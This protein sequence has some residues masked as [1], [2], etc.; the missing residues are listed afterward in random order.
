MY[1]QVVNVPCP[2]A[3]IHTFVLKWVMNRVSNGMPLKYYFSTVNKS[4]S[5][6][7]KFLLQIVIN[8]VITVVYKISSQKYL[9]SSSISIMKRRQNQQNQQYKAPGVPLVAGI[10]RT[11]RIARTYVDG[12]YKIQDESDSDDG[13]KIEYEDNAFQPHNNYSSDEEYNNAED[14]VVENWEWGPVTDDLEILDIPDHYDGPHGLKAG[15]EK[16]LVLL[17]S[18][19][20]HKWTRHILFK[21]SD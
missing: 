14:R 17:L 20:S 19:L 8:K 5:N 12:E 21:K 2:S 3:G 15:T 1:R 11:S 4:P 7:N 16:K 10:H 13:S 9:T 6:T 18:D